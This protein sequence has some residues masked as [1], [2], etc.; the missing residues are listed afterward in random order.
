MIPHNSD[1]DSRTGEKKFKWIVCKW[2][3]HNILLLVILASPFFCFSLQHMSV[4]IS[5]SDNNTI[6]ASNTPATLLAMITIVSVTK[7][8]LH[9][10]DYQPCISRW[11]PDEGVI[12]PMIGEMVA[13][14]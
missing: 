4:T 3:Y 11:L 2:L 7:G 12:L 14:L 1:S 6:N 8:Y 13:R 10:H 5:I 9:H